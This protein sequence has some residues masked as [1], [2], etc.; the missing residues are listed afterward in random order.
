MGEPREIAPASLFLVSDDS[1]FVT[2]I[3]LS[4]DWGAAQI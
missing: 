2:A 4:V 1:N 3:E